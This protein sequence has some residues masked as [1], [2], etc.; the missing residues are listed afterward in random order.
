MNELADGPGVGWLYW[1]AVGVGVLA[2]LALELTFFGR[3]ISGDR[4]GPFDDP[5]PRWRRTA[6][7]WFPLVMG[8]VMGGAYVVARWA[9]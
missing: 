7:W 2:W 1:L 5:R 8:A 6:W 9:G 4:P 3:A